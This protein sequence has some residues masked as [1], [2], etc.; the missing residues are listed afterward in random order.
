MPFLR[1][2]LF[3]LALVLVTAGPVCMGGCGGGSATDLP[4]GKVTGKVTYNGMPVT[5]GSLT[6]GP[7][8][9]GEKGPPPGK[10]ASADVQLDGSFSLSTYD[11]DD[12]AVIGRHTV[13]YIAPAVSIDE[14]QHSEDS[15]PAVSPFAGLIPSKAEVEVKSG[16]NTI[17]IELVPDPKATTPGS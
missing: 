13:Q 5:G 2:S 10:S 12:G 4:T 3:R 15:K 9:S 11:K 8:G 16:T 7:T 14:K 17:D 6:F 1:L